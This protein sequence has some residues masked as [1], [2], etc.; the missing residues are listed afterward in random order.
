MPA[1]SATDAQKLEHLLGATNPKQLT[2]NQTNP[3]D[4]AINVGDLKTVAKGLVDKGV[5]CQVDF[6]ENQPIY[7]SVP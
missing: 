4:K 1:Q 3:L 7:L 5:G 6:A 2:G